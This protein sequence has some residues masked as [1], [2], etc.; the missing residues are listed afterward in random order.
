[1]KQVRIRK[2]LGL[3]LLAMTFSA[4]AG[5]S[6]EA[7]ATKDAEKEKSDSLNTLRILLSSEVRTGNEVLI[8]KNPRFA[9][10]LLR[11]SPQREAFLQDLRDSSLFHP[12]RGPREFRAY[13]DRVEKENGVR[14]L[15]NQM[16]AHD[17]DKGLIPKAYFFDSSVVVYPGWI[18]VRRKLHR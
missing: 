3:S 18:I 2:V 13:W 1:M 16:A 11:N 7:V 6:G 14:A 10:S 8:P 4:Y 17:V 12:I 15:K 5:A 9:D